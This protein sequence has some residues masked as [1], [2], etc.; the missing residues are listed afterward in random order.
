M[1]VSVGDHLAGQFSSALN[2][3][4]LG[5]SGTVQT[6]TLNA[7]LTTEL[8]RIGA[9]ITSI[10][11]SVAKQ[12]QAFRDIIAPLREELRIR[13]A[14]LELGFVPASLRASFECLTES[15]TKQFAAFDETLAP[16]REE[17]RIRE[18]ISDLGFVPHAVLFKHLGNVGRPSHLTTDEFSQALADEAW[19]KVKASLQLS[20]E[21]C[22]GDEKIFRTFG[23]IIRAHEAGLYQ[24]TEPGAFHVIERAARLAQLG[25]KR[26]K[27]FDW[28]KNGLGDMTPYD[29]P[30]QWR[31][32]WTEVW[33]LL[34]EKTF[35]DV[36]TDEDADTLSFPHR[37]ASAHGIGG[38]I[39]GTRES[40]NCVLLAHF[41]ISAAAA[42]QSLARDESVQCLQEN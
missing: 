13:E 9:E 41:V 32:G 22:L 10:S 14:I 21:D 42:F 11:E 18:R 4:L 27:T 17:Q 39:N 31:R 24:L 40:L 37:H 3:R 23:E 19:P 29:V 30:T 38:K 35:C 15:I 33:A 36:R 1:S 34:Y 7:S 25:P 12:N 16:V 8:G 6:L 5:F 2:E 20:M 26:K 28:L